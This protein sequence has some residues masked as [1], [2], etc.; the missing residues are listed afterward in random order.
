[1]T[2][3][4]NTCG[5]R[6]AT[7]TSLLRH[8]QH[9]GHGRN[10][11]CGGYHFPHRPGSACCDAHSYVRANRAVRAGATQEERL[12]AFIDDTLFNTHKPTSA[13]CPF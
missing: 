6:R 10:C 1:M 7:F 13:P 3:R 9:A 2:V 8:K 4:C 11:D 5:T 12:D